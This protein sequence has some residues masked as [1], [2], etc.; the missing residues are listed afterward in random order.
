[1]REH[2]ERRTSWRVVTAN[3]FI[4]AFGAV[5][6]YYIFNM[7]HSIQNQRANNGTQTQALN[8]TNR[9][10]QLVH[11]A[12]AEANLFAFTDNP[13]HLK[14]FGELNN[15]ISQCADSI[16]AVMPSPENERRIHE[17]EHLIMR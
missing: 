5:M 13:A 4:I 7:Q 17:V 14:R 8:L 3:L 6:F 11:E 16:L 15:E 2:I 1:M 12:Q 10:T 9:F